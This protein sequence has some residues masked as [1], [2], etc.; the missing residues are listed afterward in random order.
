M[1]F[2]YLVPSSGQGLRNPLADTSLHVLL[3]LKYYHKCI[4]GDESVAD[5]SD[6]R[7]AVD[8]QVNTYF[9]ENPYCKAL[10]N[11][12]DIERELSHI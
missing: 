7:A 11:A 2:N 3:I 6:D 10:E 12:R 5:R 1:P 4:V 8:S 9:S